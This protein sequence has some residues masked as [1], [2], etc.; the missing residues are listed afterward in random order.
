MPAE[1]IHVIEFQGNEVMS[2]RE[3]HTI[4]ESKRQFQNW[5]KF[6]KEQ[7]NLIE[8]TDYQELNISK[9]NDITNLLN[10]SKIG[11]DR[12]SIDYALTLQAAEIIA[13]SENTEKGKEV[14]RQIIE[15]KNKQIEVLKNY[16]EKRDA[17]MKILVEQISTQLALQ[18]STFE[19]MF[20][21]ME[22]KQMTNQ[23][24]A[25]EWIKEIHEMLEEKTQQSIKQEQP[26]KQLSATQVNFPTKSTIEKPEP[27][28]SKLM[29]YIFIKASES[30]V[31][32]SF[33]FEYAEVYEATGISLQNS[34][35]LLTKLE[36]QK[37]INI[38]WANGICKSVSLNNLKPIPPEQKKT[39]FFG[40][41]FSK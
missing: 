29:D 9:S 7:L 12:K 28:L 39:G 19:S 21:R 14:A 1:L 8:N 11:G 32:G 26:T 30:I 36:K 34:N 22:E 25:M 35:T 5:F 15:R 40:K 18:T 33:V 24:E 31:R 3:L 20:A 4:L 23:E 27:Q 41:L 10:Q 6:K 38:V 37:V 17:E 16:V 13:I 2:A